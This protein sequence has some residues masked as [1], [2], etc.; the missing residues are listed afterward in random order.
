MFTSARG[1]TAESTISFRLVRTAR[2]EERELTATLKAGILT[3]R[4]G[5]TYIEFIIVILI[6]SLA[7]IIVLP[8]FKEIFPSAYLSSSARYVANEI[9]WLYHEAGFEGKSYRLNI[10]LDSDEYWVSEEAQAGETDEVPGSVSGAKNLLPGVSF[11]DVVVGAVK[12]DRGEAH[13]AF[14]PG[15]VLEPA[16]IHLVNSEGEEI[17]ITVDCLT[18]RTQIHGGYFK[19]SEF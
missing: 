1:W 18:G 11:R 13:I 3:K 7:L 16:V 8:D 10:D 15:G 6:L 17:S 2:R 9:I 12:V 4:T 14:L 5:F 19:V